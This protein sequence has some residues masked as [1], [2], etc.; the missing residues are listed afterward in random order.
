MPSPLD[1]TFLTSVTPRQSGLF[2]QAL[3]VAR[4]PWN[5]C[6]LSVVV[7]TV[8]EPPCPGHDDYMCT[9]H[10]DGISTVYIREGAD[11]PDAP[12]NA[13]VRG[14]IDQFFMESVMHEVGH[15]FCFTYLGDPPPDVPGWFVRGTERGTSADWSPLT[16]DWRDRVTEG[17]AEFFKDLY[18]PRQYRT[19]DSRANWRLDQASFGQFVQA[20]EAVICP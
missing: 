4:F 12:F 2:M 19:G 1:L 8:A 5:R 6:G 16:A 3:T 9:V 14:Q 10:Q 18:M 15:A 7:N 11:D 20:I 17:F 13:S